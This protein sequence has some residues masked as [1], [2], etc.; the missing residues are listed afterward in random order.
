MEGWGGVT[1]GV[2]CGTGG[3]VDIDGDPGG[4]GGWN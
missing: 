2:P 1:G 4:R 3:G